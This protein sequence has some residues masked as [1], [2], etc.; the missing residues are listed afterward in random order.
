[1]FLQAYVTKI[2][3]SL[4][5]RVHVLKNIGVKGVSLEEMKKAGEGLHGRSRNEQAWIKEIERKALR[6]SILFTEVLVVCLCSSLRFAALDSLFT[7]R[8]NLRVFPI[9]LTHFTPEIASAAAAGAAA[10]ALNA[11]YVLEIL[12]LSLCVCVSLRE[13]TRG[14]A[15]EALCTRVSL[16][17]AFVSSI[18]PSVSLLSFSLSAWM[19]QDLSFAPLLC[20]VAPYCL[21][22]LLLFLPFRYSLFLSIVFLPLSFF[23]SH[24][25]L[26]FL[27]SFSVDES[28]SELRP[29][30]L[31][32]GTLLPAPSNCPPN[33]T[34]IVIEIDKI[35][36]K[37]AQQ[38]ID[39][40]ITVTATGL[41]GRT[42]TKRQ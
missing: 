40:L 30:A 24:F 13:T 22:P 19:S 32:G 1:M 36:L 39:A 6:N 38:Y 18:F 33:T 42:K 28:G 12:F 7:K 34:S 11:V 15:G 14:D 27:L 2:R 4:E 35:G 9:D 21:L 3:N 37:D 23:P 20:L 26:A 17:F 41:L 5:Y 8:Q 25:F 31:L 16:C 10:G 29:A